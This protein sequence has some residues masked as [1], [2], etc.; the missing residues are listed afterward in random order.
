MYEE[1]M[2]DPETVK[3]TC[4]EVL[5]HIRDLHSARHSTITVFDIA[6]FLKNVQYQDEEHRKNDATQRLRK[7]ERSGYIEKLGPDKKTAEKKPSLPE[8]GAQEKEKRPRGRPAAS[9]AITKKGAEYARTIADLY[10]TE[11]GE[12]VDREA[13]SPFLKTSTLLIGENNVTVIVAT[14]SQ[15]IAIAAVEAWMK[16]TQEPFRATKIEPVTLPASLK[17]GQDA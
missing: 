5:A 1:H 3:T 14:Q 4:L 12:I 13:V 16:A 10:L 15:E 11:T 2:P 6:E 7:L 8:L 9:Y 17:E